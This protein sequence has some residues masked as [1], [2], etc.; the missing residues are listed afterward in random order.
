M[1]CCRIITR[2]I[3][4]GVSILFCLETGAQR[5]SNFNLYA[6]GKSVSVNFTIVKGSSCSGYSVFHSL[7]SVNF[8]LIEDYAGICSSSSEDYSNSYTHTNPTQNHFNYYKVQ[9]A[10]GEVSEVKSIYVTQ[11]SNSGLILYPN[12][13]GG[14]DDQMNFRALASPN[15]HLSGYIYDVNGKKYADLDV[16]TYDTKA[17]FSV[18]GFKSGIY[19]VWL[20]DG[21]LLYT[22]K[23][24]VLY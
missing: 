6:V 22:G 3:L 20:S 16:K 4:F 15:N 1:D 8:S 21:E 23:F 17:S 13:I 9:I 18:S 7:D 19:F 24:I 14:T 5:I 11:N 10:I 2:F 12:P